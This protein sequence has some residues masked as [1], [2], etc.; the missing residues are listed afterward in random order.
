MKERK[1]IQNANLYPPRKVNRQ[2]VILK[3]SSHFYCILEILTTDYSLIQT[4]KDF[5][6]NPT[7][8]IQRINSEF[9]SILESYISNFNLTS[10]Y[11]ARVKFLTEI[12]NAEDEFSWTKNI[13]EFYKEIMFPNI[14]VKFYCSYCNTDSY[15]HFNI[16]KL[17][18]THLFA[19]TINNAICPSVCSQCKNSK[20]VTSIQ[21]NYL[22]CLDVEDSIQDKLINLND[23]K[24][25]LDLEEQSL[26]LVAV[27]GFE[28]P[29]GKEKLR[30]YVAYSS[31]FNGSWL[32]CDS[33]QLSKR[34]SRLPKNEFDI[35]VALVIYAK[36]DLKK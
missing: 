33:T 18:Y 15:E 10:L 36:Y 12:C 29:I 9:L 16:I 24:I 26:I 19:N 8:A 11:N 20:F 3:T 23:M 22:L 34:I 25:T 13:G 21:V 32:K 1:L 2:S 31:N 6:N 27:I 5:V 4:F 35:K 17:S 30:H 28:E 7:D 14:F